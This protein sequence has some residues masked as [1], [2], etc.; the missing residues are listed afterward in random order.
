MRSIRAKWL[1]SAEGRLKILPGLRQS[2]TSYPPNSADASWR[3]CGRAGGHD[4]DT[5]RGWCG[6]ASGPA[7]SARDEDVYRHVVGTTKSFCPEAVGVRAHRLFYDFTLVHVYREVGLQYDSSCFLPM[8]PDLRP[9]RS[10]RDLVEIPI[11]YMDYWDLLEGASRWR[12][13]AL[14]LE[15]PGVKVFDFHPNLVFMN[16]STMS[17]YVASKDYYRDAERLR[18]LRRSGRGVRTL[19]LDLLDFIA[20][21]GAETRGLADLNTQWRE[22]SRP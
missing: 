13:D 2:L 18:A 9:V 6:P 16:A 20:A 12:L 5:L 15:Q 21:K 11:Y 3:G 7:S 22:H 19:F 14:P 17:E 10:A 1:T 8:A 4:G